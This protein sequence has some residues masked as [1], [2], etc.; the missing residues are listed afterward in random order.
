MSLSL[1]AKR[2]E[3]ISIYIAFFWRNT[4]VFTINDRVFISKGLNTAFVYNN[5]LQILIF[6]RYNYFII[7]YSCLSTSYYKFKYFSGITI[8]LSV[9]PVATPDTAI[10]DP[11]AGWAAELRR[12]SLEVPTYR[13]FLSSP[14]NSR[15][16][17]SV[18]GIAIFHKIV[19]FCSSYCMIYNIK[20]L[21]NDSIFCSY[22]G[23][24]TDPPC[25]RPIQI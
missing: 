15:D 12:Y 18:A 19:R 6:S 10:I 5:I 7:G 2:A 8:S 22:T 21:Q 14:P 11:A 3:N 16:T 23:I 1:P 4:D 9:I 20:L 17:I 13:V 25:N 24:L